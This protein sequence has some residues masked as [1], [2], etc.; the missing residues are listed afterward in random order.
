MHVSVVHDAPRA[1]TFIQSRQSDNCP[2]LRIWEHRSIKPLCWKGRRNENDR[3]TFEQ[4]ACGQPPSE[5]VSFDP[6]ETPIFTSPRAGKPVDPSKHRRSDNFA[7]RGAIECCAGSFSLSVLLAAHNT[8]VSNV[9]RM[10]EE[11]RNGQQ[12]NK[13]GGGR[14]R[15]LLGGRAMHV[16]SIKLAGAL[17]PSVCGRGVIWAVSSD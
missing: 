2:R 15:F 4:P 9:V 8:S 3:V 11:V 17:L 7:P 6:P 12:V 14:R 10:S 13:K 5:L 1:V 16:G